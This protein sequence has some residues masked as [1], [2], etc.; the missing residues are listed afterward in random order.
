MRET[1]GP[2]ACLTRGK[3]TCTLAKGSGCVIPEC[4]YR[5][6][7]PPSKPHEPTRARPVRGGWA[8][9]TSIRMLR[10]ISDKAGV[11]LLGLALCARLGQAQAPY[12]RP[13]PRPAPA[14]AATI[15]ASEAM[16]TTMCALYAAGYESKV[17]PDNWTVFRAQMRD[18]LRQQK[19]PAVDVLKDFYR[20][21][22]FRDP[23][24]M[25]S[26]FVW[27]GLISGPAPKFQPTMRR[28][29]LPPEVLDLEG[30][31][32][33]LSN[34]YTEQKI[35]A[36]WREVQPLYDREIE[37]LHDPVT[38]ILFV[39]S[40]YVRQV[41]DP[42][43]PGTFSIIVEPLVGKITNVRSFGD[44]YALVLSGSDEF[45]TDVVRHAYLHFLLDTLPLEYSHVVV[46][47]RPL[48]EM[49]AKAPRLPPDLKDD[50]F[51][52]FGEC[53]VRAV[54]IKLRRLSPSEREAV[55]QKNDNDGYV[56]VRPIFQGLTEFE[57]SE[58]NF[59]DYFP[60]LVRGIDMKAEE[61]RIAAI[62]FAPEQTAAEAKEFSSE[63][64][65]RKRARAVT[66]VP[67]DPTAVAA[68][69]EGEKHIA[70]KNPRAAESSFLS[71]L[72]KYPDQ[73][74]AWYGM[75]LVALLDHDAEKAKEVFGRLTT[76]DHA[77]SQ[78][79]MVMAWS[80]VYLARIFEDEGQLERAKA[81]YQAVLA[82]QGAP[83]Q[84]QQAAQKG[85]GDLEMRKPS[86][87]P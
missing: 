47:K 87:R 75:G 57:K 60:D 26:R 10:K 12:Q 22:Q 16:F 48:Y 35:H 23:G 52:W 38:Q 45:P 36:L 85:L 82:V 76:G 20:G 51:S 67:N 80:H 2:G 32:E 19:G 73:T 65:A 69:T 77:A 46:V 29:E 4:P 1:G 9:L 43:M 61:T 34:Y 18:R 28:D 39:A 27:F 11:I 58:P 6:L 15:D 24:A 54:E 49:A 72:A 83:M 62:H 59:H 55:L 78:D 30:F 50:F 13:K 66:T 86:E 8:R 74:R 84:A 68:L 44:H 70:E 37:R 63:A 7:I 53:T 5:L 17:S 33:I 40:T 14:T 21:H 71:V 3:G 42:A 31:S 81:E 64:L 41:V 79:P 25:L 56:M